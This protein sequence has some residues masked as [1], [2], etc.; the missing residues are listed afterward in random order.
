MEDYSDS[1]TSSESEYNSDQMSITGS[2]YDEDEPTENLEPELSETI[3]KEYNNCAWNPQAQL[4]AQLN[5]TCLAQ[6]HAEIKARAQLPDLTYQKLLCSWLARPFDIQ[7]LPNYIKHL[8]N[9]FKLFWGSEVWNTLVENT[10][11]YAQYKEARNKENKE[12]KSRWWKAVTLYE[13]RIFIAILIYMGIVSASNISSYWNKNRLTIH[14]P[15]EYITFFRFEQIKRYFHISPP[16]S[17]RLPIARWHTKLSP[18]SD[19]LCTKF[20]AYVV[21]GQDVS[22]DEMMVPFS[23]RS[24][25]T[26][27]MKNKPIKEG[28][29]IWALCDHGYL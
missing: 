9:Y 26:L 16:I 22:F 15:M 19:L 1:D 14:K 7:I 27:K 8:I 20:K 23:G 24:K 17:T 13:M 29:K 5:A 2:D 12:K 28:F 21:L 18:L 10:N 25:H 3:Y 11:A 6:L 4:Q